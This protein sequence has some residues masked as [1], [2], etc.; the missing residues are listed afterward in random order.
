MKKIFYCFILAV[1][2]FTSSLAQNPYFLF[3]PEGGFPSTAVIPFGSQLAGITVYLEYYNVIGNGNLIK[4]TLIVAVD[5]DVV[6]PYDLCSVGFGGYV[7]NSYTVYLSKGYHEVTYSLL[8]INPN[9]K[10]C[11]D[12]VIWQSDTY[13][14]TVKFKVAVQNNFA[15]GTV[16]VDGVTRNSPYYRTSYTGEN[17]TIGAIEQTGGAYSYIWNTNGTNNSDWNYKL[18]GSGFQ[19]L[20]TSQSTS[21][22]VSSGEK[23]TILQA[24]L[25]KICNL[26]FSNQ[27]TGTTET[28]EMK[29][30]GV[31]YSAP[32]SAFAVVEQN[33]ISAKAVYQY[34]VN[35]IQYTFQYWQN[36]TG[37]RSTTFYPGAH[38]NYTAVYRGV[39]IFNDITNRN[40]T[41]N[42]YSPRTEKNVKLTWSEHQHISV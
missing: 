19:Q 26:T 29:V 25:R 6:S 27:F 21:Y 31:T 16:V 42:T 12:Q 1:G 5:G 8:S 30:N 4:P 34:T 20:S 36:E 2:I 41:F 10:D 28:G 23:N 24:G 15:G 33:A 13:S 38:K 11:Y 35:N 14:I 32:T 17:I 22:S 18:E 7:P 40:L 39:P 9:T 37:G 3:A